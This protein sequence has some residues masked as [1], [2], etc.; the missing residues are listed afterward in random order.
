[1][2]YTDGLLEATPKGSRTAAF[3]E[4]IREKMLRLEPLSPKE[5]VEGLMLEL[6]LFRQGEDFDDDICLICMAVV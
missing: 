2:L 6:I 1:V 5:F 3:K 4:V